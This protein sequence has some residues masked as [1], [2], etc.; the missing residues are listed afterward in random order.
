VTSPAPR[1]SIAVLSLGAFASAANMRVTDPL[2]PQIAGDLGASVGAASIVITAYAVAYGICQILYG[3]LGDRLGKYLTVAVMTV[4]SGAATLFSAI[5]TDVTGLAIAR[6]VSG[7]TS[8]AIIPLALAWVGDT[9]R[10]ED[11]QPVLARF[12]IGQILGLTLGQA[13]GGALGEWLG[14][15]MAYVVLAV[16]FVLAGAA[17]LLELR[18]NR[19]YH[20]AAAR[21]AGNL[22][23]LALLAVLHRP[24]ARFVVGAVAAEGFIFFGAFA[25]IGADLHDRAGVDL[26]TVG[27]VLAPFGL[28]G[29]LYV[30]A[31]RRI[32][33][34]L[35][36]AR[37]ALAGT[38]IIAV[39]FVCLALVS[40]ALFAAVVML[41]GGVGFYLVHNTLQVNGTEMAPQARGASV[42]L[43]AICFFGGQSAGVACAGPLLDR[44]GAQPLFLAA[45]AAMALL[46]FC[47]WWLLRH[48]QRWA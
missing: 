42:S 21:G 10:Y 25:F 46:G 39:M 20:G 27:L 47:L 15:R 32:V 40:N 28:G 17:L 6:L 31:A 36:E 3:P 34:R 1:R 37:M 19:A 11:R 18:A 24:W 4:V 2:L 45:G 30:F 8:A 23:P 13:A 33:G 9:V 16:L 7:A 14:W 12:L 44:F 41:V 43:F 5:A 26:G 35:G 48:K 38:L 29:L 22:S